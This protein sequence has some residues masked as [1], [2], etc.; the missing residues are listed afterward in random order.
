M[1]YQIDGLLMSGHDPIAEIKDGLLISINHDRLPFYLQRCN[2]LYGWLSE[3]A[4]DRHRTN[5][6]LLKRLAR[7]S[8]A[9]DPDVAMKVYGATI[10]DNFWVKPAGTDLKYE[11]V[12]FYANPFADTALFGSLAPFTDGS[13][14]NNTPSPELTN[15]GSFEK[16][17]KKED[18]IWW[19]YKQGDIDSKYAE[20]FMCEL[21]K[22][23]GLTM[24]HYELAG[25]YIR[26]KD[27]TGDASVN[28]DPASGLIG[29][30]YDDYMLNYEVF[31]NVSPSVSGA[32][33][34]MLYL[35][36][37]CNNVDRHENNY[38]L[39]RDSSTG[40]V[41]SFAPLYDHNIALFCKHAGSPPATLYS[42][43]L[44]SEFYHFIK[45]CGVSFEQPIIDEASL[46]CVVQRVPISYDENKVVQFILGRQKVLEHNLSLCLG[47][48]T[49][50]CF[51][52]CVPLDNQIRTA[53]SIAEQGKAADNAPVKGAIPQR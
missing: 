47:H 27:V 2:D 10:T 46:R 22:A 28:L 14:S 8:S 18:G 20:L 38:A 33:V 11:Q 36:A 45:D 41:L 17:W 19:L 1:R 51:A 42:D 6:R 26:S 31:S 13:W 25:D 16:C 52:A 48:S 53:S 44:I 30:N 12:R 37:L 29:N 34:N 21:G 50:K 15:T 9:N 39:L 35:D 32:Y 40:S 49:R 4:I 24:A 5:S 7:I 3:R 23:L 43:L